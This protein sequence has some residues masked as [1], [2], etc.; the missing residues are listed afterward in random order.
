MKPKKQHLSTVP[1]S[2]PFKISLKKF[3]SY[4]ISIIIEEYLIFNYDKKKYGFPS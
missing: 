4:I 2:Y 3:I 1:K